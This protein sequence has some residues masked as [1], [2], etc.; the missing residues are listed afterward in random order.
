[1]IIITLSIRELLATAEW[2]MKIRVRTSDAGSPR[3]DA[4]FLSPSTISLIHLLPQFEVS[5]FGWYQ[6]W[7]MSPKLCT[8]DAWC[9]SDPDRR[10]GGRWPEL[11]GSTFESQQCH[12]TSCVSWG[13]CLNF[14]DLVSLPINGTSNTCFAGLSWGWSNR[15]N[16]MYLAQY[17]A[18]NVLWSGS[19][20]YYREV[21]SFSYCWDMF[22]LPPVE[23][24][25]QEWIIC[26]SVK[27]HHIIYG[28]VFRTAV[29]KY[30]RLSVLNSRNS[31]S[32]SPEG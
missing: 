12:L 32:Y 29:T 4:F 9:R 15:M 31:F 17:P 13:W 24:P 8:T 27:E 3:E 26:L 16:V 25:T 5:H 11:N 22:F 19:H 7:Q 30:Q 23:V 28:L 18:H 10:L 1:M 20:S 2:A 6:L 14:T 21:F